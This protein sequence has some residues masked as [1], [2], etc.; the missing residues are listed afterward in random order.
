[1]RLVRPQKLSGEGRAQRIML[2]AAP[3]GAV[4]TAPLGSRIA[5]SRTGRAGEVGRAGARSAEGGAGKPAGVA[6]GDHMQWSLGLD[7][8]LGHAEH[9]QHVLAS[10]RERDRGAALDLRDAACEVGRALAT[11]AERWVCGQVE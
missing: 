6:T 4:G 9:V 11:S 2:G 8:P 5:S 10:A 7:V 3:L 1:M